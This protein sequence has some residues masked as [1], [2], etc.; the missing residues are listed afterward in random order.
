MKRVE[1]DI[2]I[3]E[4]LNIDPQ[5]EP[6]LLARG[7]HCLHCIAASGET[8]EQACFVHGLDVNVVVNDINTYLA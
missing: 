6:L 4:L 7:M 3:A 2:I 5:I 8:L 1:P